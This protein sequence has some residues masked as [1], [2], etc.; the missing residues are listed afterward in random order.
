MLGRKIHTL[1][2]LSRDA[3][4][5]LLVGNSYIAFPIN[6]DEE[7]G[8]A[9]FCSIELSAPLEVSNGFEALCAEE[10]ENYGFL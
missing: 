8:I 4:L 1:L 9:T 3:K 7:S 2:E 5:P 6:L 10:V